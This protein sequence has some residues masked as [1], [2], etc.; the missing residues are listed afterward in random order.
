MDPDTATDRTLVFTIDIAYGAFGSISHIIVGNL[1]AIHGEVTAIDLNTASGGF[2]AFGKGGSSWIR[3]SWVRVLLLQISQR[4]VGIPGVMGNV[5]AIVQYGIAHHF[6][7]IVAVSTFDLTPGCLFT[8]LSNRPSCINRSLC[9]LDCLCRI[10]SVNLRQIS[11]LRQVSSLLRSISG[12]LSG[13]LSVL[14]LLR[15]R[16]RLLRLNSRKYLSSLHSLSCLS[17]HGILGS[18]GSLIGGFLS[19]LSC[20]FLGSIFCGYSG[21]DFSLRRINRSLSRINCSLSRSLVFSGCKGS[22]SVLK[23]RFRRSSVVGSS[24]SNGLSSCLSCH[25]SFSSLGSFSSSLGSS[26]GFLSGLVG[27]VL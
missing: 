3:S 12:S 20:C 18:L 8:V 11:S 26:L 15:I 14:Q 22:L 7:N 27:C 5:D 21:I 2:C 1:T 17:E 9:R 6:N 24:I 13:S 19:S 4:F 23:V 16:I 10:R 25:F